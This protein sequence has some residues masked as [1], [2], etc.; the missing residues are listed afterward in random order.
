MLTPSDNPFS[1]AHSAKS[2]ASLMGPRAQATKLAGIL[3]ALQRL[4]QQGLY[5]T[6]KRVDLEGL[7][8]VE[9][10]FENCEFVIQSGNFNLINCRIYGPETRFLYSG[11]ALK[12]AKVYEFMNASVQQKVVFPALFPQVDADGRITI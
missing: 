11:G 1:S 2:L 5:F 3:S 10:A 9:C 6:R 8:F 4:Q 12:V 7:T